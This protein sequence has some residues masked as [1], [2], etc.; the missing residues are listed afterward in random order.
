MR[1]R[2]AFLSVAAL[3]LTACATIPPQPNRQCHFKIVPVE[4]TLPTI[5][6]PP[7][8]QI[9]ADKYAAGGTPTFLLM[10]GGSEHGAFGAGIL[11]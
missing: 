9:I 1:C 6:P 7:L 4:V 8:Q 10:S 11:S 5:G 3:F 2:T